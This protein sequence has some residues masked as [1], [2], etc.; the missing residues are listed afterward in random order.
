MESFV[1]NVTICQVQKGELREVKSSTI[2]RT[3]TATTQDIKRLL[4]QESDHF[5]S[6]KSESSITLLDCKGLE[7]ENTSATKDD[8]Y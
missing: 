3:P 5:R 8:L 4:I 6:V 1:K 7:T 2:M